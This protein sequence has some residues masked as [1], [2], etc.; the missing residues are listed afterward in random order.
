[1]TSQIPGHRWTPKLKNSLCKSRSSLG[2]SHTS[3][4]EVMVQKNGKKW[5]SLENQ[6]NRDSKLLQCIFIRDKSHMGLNLGTS[7]LLGLFNSQDGAQYFPPKWQGM[8][9]RIHSIASHKKMLFIVTAMGTL[10]ST[11][12][13]KL[14]CY[15]IL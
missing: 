11:Q 6:S 14:L 9:T 7:Y 5:L 12:S 2:L 13:V 8:F 1:M 10:K 4:G 15:I 3:G